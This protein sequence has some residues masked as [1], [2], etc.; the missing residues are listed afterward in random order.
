MCNGE[1]RYKRVLKEQIHK[2]DGNGGKLTIERRPG[3]IKINNYFITASKLKSADHRDLYIDFTVVNIFSDSYID[4]SSKK[5]GEIAR[6]KE[7]HKDSEYHKK[8]N[9]Q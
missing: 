2:D 1:I 8:P 7:K 5:R 9:I 4:L 3:D 6:K